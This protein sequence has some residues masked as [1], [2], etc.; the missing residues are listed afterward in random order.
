MLNW[1][2]GYCYANAAF[3]AGLVLILFYWIRRADFIATQVL[4]TDIDGSPILPAGTIQFMIFL[5][6]V[7]L[8]MFGGVCFW[9]PSAKKNKS[10]WIVHLVNCAL[11]LGSCLFTPISLWVLILLLKPEVRHDF[12]A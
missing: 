5:V 11:G 8:A 7:M 3:Y 4:P 6:I 9:L 1:Y 12:G 10:M 2:K